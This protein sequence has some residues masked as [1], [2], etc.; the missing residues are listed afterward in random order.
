[1]HR[2]LSALLALLPLGLCLSGTRPA[3]A[4][5]RDLSQF[6][7]TDRDAFLLDTPTAVALGDVDQAAWSPSGKYVLARRTR[8]DPRSG[9]A[10]GESA[11]CLWSAE[12]GK[13]RD[14]WKG[15]GL[16]SVEWVEWLP[17]TETA[18]ALV[19]R[20]APEV[21]L[22]GATGKPE[23]LVLQKWVLRVDARRGV[24][25]QLINVPLDTEAQAS[26]TR[27]LAWLSSYERVL[28]LVGVEGAVRDLSRALPP[29]VANSPRWSH[30]GTALRIHGAPNPPAGERARFGWYT[31]ALDSL[32][33]SGPVRTLPAEEAEERPSA[34]HRGRFRLRLDEAPLVRDKTRRTVQPLWIESVIPSEQPLVL[35]TAHCLGGQTL[36]PRQDAV[37]YLGEGGAW[38]RPLVRFDKAV[39]LEARDTARRVTL[40]SNA[41]QLGT[42]LHLYADRDDK[43]LPAAGADLVQ[44]LLPIVKHESLFEDFV[45]TFPGGKL[46]DIPDPANTTLGFTPAPN[47]RIWLYADGH[48]K[49]IKE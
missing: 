36:S 47:G 16:A 5:P 31:L 48:V 38:V 39:F 33:L 40:M 34:E 13:S 49:Y 11:L 21:R 20:P 8:T 44:L 28:G 24:V 29:Q 7:V 42:G 43:G 45:Y 12:T 14:L 17:G 26:P 10:S 1:M 41:K 23:P 32:K 18:I 22:A 9:P 19:R 2:S 46:A 15:Q 30:D 4:L 25:Q 37:L 35:I 27:P 3:Q 6:V